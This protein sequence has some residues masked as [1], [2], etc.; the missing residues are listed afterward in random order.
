M[1][2]RKLDNKG[3]TLVELI[4]VLV[5]LAILAAILVPALLGYID[6][7]KTKQDILKARNLFTSTQAEFIKLY[8]KSKGSFMTPG[9][10]VSGSKGNDYD[11]S[12]T[13]WVN[14]I[15]TRADDKPFAFIVGLGFYGSGANECKDIHEAYTVY[16]A[17]YCSKVDSKPIYFDGQ[18]WVSDYPWT[19][20]GK[21]DG[22]N[23]FD[24]KGIGKKKL[25]LYVLI[26][27][28]S[29]PSWMNSYN[30]NIW[31]FFRYNP[32]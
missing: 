9:E 30:K 19:T 18:E 14:N 25:Q 32:N 17:A 10:L 13:N 22:D 1:K 23:V 21:G 2:M 5:I 31:N 28:S 16:F 24:I 29:Y 11:L 27:P 4:V 8:S 26:T 20:Q 6:E 15:Y 3:F 7:A 12:K